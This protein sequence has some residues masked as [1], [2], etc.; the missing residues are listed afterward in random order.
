LTKKQKIHNIIHNI[1]FHT[2]ENLLG[3]GFMKKAFLFFCAYLFFIFN[4]QA[5]IDIDINEPYIPGQLVVKFRSDKIKYRTRAL[6]YIENMDYGMIDKTKD[7]KIFLVNTPADKDITLSIIDLYQTG[8]FQYVSPNYIFT[9][10]E[11]PNDTYWQNLWALENTGQVIE[12]KDRQT[13]EIK[14]YVG[15]PGVDLD[16]K[17]AWEYTKGSK[18]I[19][20]AIIDTGVFYNHP[21]LADNIWVN[22]DEIPNN[23]IDDDNNGYVDDVRGWDFG[24]AESIPP[25]P[26]PRAYMGDRPAGSPNSDKGDNDPNDAHIHGTHV[27]GIIGARG[28]NGIGIVGVNQE[29]SIMPVK[30]LNESGQGNLFN[31]IEAVKY[32]A[33]NQARVINAS[34]G[35]SLPMPIPLLEEAINDAI[36]NKNI[37]FVAAAGN[38][39][40]DKVG[41]NN[42]ALGGETPN[43]PSSYT[44][45]GII[46]VTATQPD[47]NITAFSNFG[48]LS[49]DVGAPGLGIYSTTPKHAE[50]GNADYFYA[51]GTSMATPFVTGLAALIL[52]YKPT[53]TNLEVRSIIFSSAEENPLLQDKV[54]TGRRIN[55]YNALKMVSENQLF[56]SPNAIELAPGETYKFKATGG[57]G[58]YNFTL[59]DV[60]VGSI[61]AMGNFKA[62]K[63]GIT[64]IMVKDSSGATANTFDIVVKTKE[65]QNLCP[66]GTVALPIG[67][68]IPGIPLLCLP[69][70]GDKCPDGT[71]EIPI[72]IEGFPPLCIPN[73]KQ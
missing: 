39:G 69:L 20:V 61:D 60:L 15:T 54:V 24:S 44:N 42:D 11:T 26:I 14:R 21:D 10:Q 29:V 62:I 17:K 2:N 19:I 65:A 63:E 18:K 12:L 34:W 25:L 51:S 37:I 55:A 36:T 67:N 13:G 68:L 9:I 47:D 30:F 71:T 22:E 5:M 1:N 33:N 57:N 50:F 72:P 64:K 49:V 8:L 3:G 16:I 45:A 41:D 23:N 7:D 56:I 27:A 46:A 35:A 73:A 70:N 48:K 6:N 53:L 52:A 4:A 31:A 59:T 40:N 28:N 66:E 43:F 58:S 38:G 32:A